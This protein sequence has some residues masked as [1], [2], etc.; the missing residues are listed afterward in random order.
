MLRDR[1]KDSLKDAM[2]AKDTTRL[3]TLRLI[4]AAIKDRD[5]AARADA[6]DRQDDDAF[7]SEILTKMVKQRRD[8]I[9]AYE[10]GGRCDMAERERAEIE[11]IESF[12][13][14]QLSESE[15]KSACRSVVNDVGAE[16]LK[17]IGRCMGALKA[18]YAGQMDFTK[19]SAEVKSLLS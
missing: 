16:S 18:R 15:I 6:P 10:E 17:D 9:K 3:A 4:L 11:V 8:S 14:K 13:P 12:L 7:V 1:L 2:R 5:I 19:A